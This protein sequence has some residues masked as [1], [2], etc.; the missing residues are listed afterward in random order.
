MTIT[1]KGD[2]DTVVKTDGILDKNN[3]CLNLRVGSKTL[4][5]KKPCH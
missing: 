1:L 2:F 4:Y 5:I 3:K